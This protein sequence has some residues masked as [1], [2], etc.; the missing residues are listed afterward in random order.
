MLPDPD[1][2]TVR[3]PYRE[4]MDVRSILDFFGAHAVEGLE[5]YDGITY[6]R[7]LSAPGGPALVAVSAG[8]GALTCRIRL[9]D[10][11]DLGAV[12]ARVRRLFDLDADPVAVDAALGTDPALAP[13][14]RK[15]PGLRSPGAADGFETAVCTVVGQQIS[16]TGARTVLGRIVAEHGAPVFDGWRMFPSPAVLAEV[17]PATLPMPRSRG[18]TI[19]AL[20]AAGLPL[21][22]G[23]DRDDLHARL[24][25]LPGIGPWTAD[26][27]RMRSGGDPDVLLASDLAVR[28]AADDL[29]LD[30]SDGR[31][32][33]APWRSY[34]THHLWVH[35]YGD[36]W[37]VAA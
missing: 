6:T 20:A 28:H 22:G 32:Q 34:A 3:L 12:T 25:A 7:V 31:P 24:L 35:L 33:W 13:L 2:I 23:A 5:S 19:V 18:R 21:D 15:H 30:L 9:H 16:V 27:L 4:P 26:Y 1:G 17:D 36:R 29:G 14:V 37:A 10:G 8:D 11:G